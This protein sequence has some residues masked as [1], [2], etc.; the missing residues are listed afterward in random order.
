MTKQRTTLRQL[1]AL[2]ALGPREKARRVYRDLERLL[3]TWRLRADT[4]VPDS[5]FAETVNELADELE[6][7]LKQPRKRNGDWLE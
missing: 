3:D 5:P 7:V 4:S 6:R 1:R 2:Y